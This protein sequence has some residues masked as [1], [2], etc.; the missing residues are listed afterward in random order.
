MLNL[1]RKT[2]LIPAATML[3][4]CA[5]VQAQQQQPPPPPASSSSSS[6]TSSASATQSVADAAKQARAQKDGSNTQSAPKTPR[7]FDNDNIPT[8]GGIS[9]VGASSGSSDN[10]SGTGAAN[11]DDPTKHEDK[12]QG[13]TNSLDGKNET[14]WRNLFKDL[15]HRLDQDQQDLA[16]SQRELGKDDVQ[17]Y[18]D[19]V[20]GMQQGLTRSDINDKTA[21]I[22]AL[23]Q[24]IQADN[25]AISNAEDQLRAAGGDSGWAR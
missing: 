5:S 19:P 8:T 9:T 12:K 2:F 7:V 16:I 20:Q 18:T 24:K 10:G 1:T 11:G 23:K 17:F 22:D 15:R 3:F 6:S 21:K 4:A 25:D 13:A 14:G